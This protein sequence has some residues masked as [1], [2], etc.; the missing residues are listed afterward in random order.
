MRK[1]SELDKAI[2]YAIRN[3][4]LGKQS[5]LQEVLGAEGKIVPQATLSRRL[6]RLPIS[7][8][9]GIYKVVDD[10]LDLYPRILSVKVS[11]SGLMVLHTRPGQANNLAYFLDQQLRG[12]YVAECE[13]SLV[14]GIIAGDDT[15]LLILDSYQSYNEVMSELVK[16]FPYLSTE[17]V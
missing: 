3:N 13:D 5:E 1:E 14:L 16:Y 11:Q 15:V 6:K 10:S 12:Y 7:K 17:P 9:G 2:I 8:V 4:K